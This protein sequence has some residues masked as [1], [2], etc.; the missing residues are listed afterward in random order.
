MSKPIGRNAPCPCGSGLKYKRC[1]E[2]KDQLEKIGADE[3]L[4]TFEDALF[5]QTYNMILMSVWA[6][7]HPKS[8]ELPEI[9]ELEQFYIDLYGYELDPDAVADLILP[10][11]RD[12]LQ[13]K[14]PQA[15]PT[16]EPDEREESRE[17][18]P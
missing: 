17:P 16:S 4:E 6:M 15:S 8:K 14:S 3:A 10:L 13:L 11:P 18:K 1:C 12:I 9:K 5:D 7:F 2:S